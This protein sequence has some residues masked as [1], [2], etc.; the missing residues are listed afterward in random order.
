[1]QRIFLI[2]IQLTIGSTPKHKKLQRIIAG[3]F[4]YGAEEQ[5]FNRLG[6]SNAHEAQPGDFQSI[7]LAS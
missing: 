2:S 3:A 7:T 5:N 4:Y 6:R 1:M